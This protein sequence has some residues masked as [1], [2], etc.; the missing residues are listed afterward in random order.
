MQLDCLSLLVKVRVAEKR[1][2]DDPEAQRAT[3]VQS[4]LANARRK[5]EGA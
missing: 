1:A 5:V 4:M 3:K 2:A